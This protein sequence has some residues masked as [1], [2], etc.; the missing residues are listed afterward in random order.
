[1]SLIKDLNT[2]SVNDEMLSAWLRFVEFSYETLIYNY[3]F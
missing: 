1:M 2:Y 3:K